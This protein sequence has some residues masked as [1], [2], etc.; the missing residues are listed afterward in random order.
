MTFEAGLHRSV[1]PKQMSGPVVGMEA[2]SPTKEEN[3]KLSVDCEK[4]WTGKQSYEYRTVV[5]GRMSNG[6]WTMPRQFLAKLSLPVE[7]DAKIDNPA[8]S[9]VVFPQKSEDRAKRR[10]AARRLAALANEGCLT[11]LR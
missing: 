11:L 6:I 2:F 10:D 3:Y 8:H 1:H 9:L 4:V 5:L 7:V